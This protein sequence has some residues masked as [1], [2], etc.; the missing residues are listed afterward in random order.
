MAS[1]SFY[2]G[3][4]RQVGHQPQTSTSH[5]SYPMTITSRMPS[6]GP[7]NHVEMSGA[8]LS[9]SGMPNSAAISLPQTSTAG[10]GGLG[11]TPAPLPTATATG[12]GDFGSFTGYTTP[13]PP[14]PFAMP[15]SLP[16][17]LPPVGDGTRDSRRQNLQNGRDE[18]TR[19]EDALRG[20]LSRALSSGLSSIVGEEERRRR[21]EKERDGNARVSGPN[22]GNQSPNKRLSSGFSIGMG[23]PNMAK[24]W[25]DSIQKAFPEANREG[26]KPSNA[27]G[28]RERDEEEAGKL[29]KK[30][31]HHH[32]HSL[33]AVHHHRHHHKVDDEPA[34][35]GL[36]IPL[37]RAG[38]RSKS[39]NSM[40]MAHPHH[41]HQVTVH[42]HHPA[43]VSP[44]PP[45]QRVKTS[46]LI[47]SSKVLASLASK[48]RQYL[49]STIYQPTPTPKQ[50]L[51]VTQ[52]L[53]PRFEGRENCIFQVRIP[54]RFLSAEQRRDVHRRRCVWGT[55]V[56]TDDSD[57]LG[58]LVHLGKVPGVLP[59]GA[60][61][62][63]VAETGCRKTT[64]RGD[65]TNM[66][67]TIPSPVRK[68]GKGAHAADEGP[69]IQPGKD[70][71]VNLLILPTLQKYTGSV[72]NAL[73]SRSWNT[74]HDGMSY[75]IWD[76]E[77]VEA[78][79]AEARGG[80]SRKRR[81][82]E[83]EWVRRWGELPPSRGGGGVGKVGWNKGRWSE[84]KTGMR[85]GNVT[86]VGA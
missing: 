48:P 84:S 55:E 63:L 56:Y 69:T 4:P 59:E 62:D 72:R 10:A 79:E 64:S 73:K 28:K 20:G 9:M 30:K 16:T 46:L 47:D 42:H 14:S 15:A 5:L 74:I 40:A 18:P 45:P 81:L 35:S 13:M 38:A 44:A 53:L 75:S 43:A 50:G 1:R 34:G 76:M 39:P 17:V 11:P 77:W 61:P 29:E 41:V 26:G 33:H 52:P 2:G 82:D 57:V 51:S 19:A 66:L 12:R 7:Q 32:H 49:G 22:A 6:N 23:M 60:T 78:G 83:R 58:V 31:K 24:S 85:K 25:D 27:L 71:I 37:A 65:I 54:R 21:V 86:E 36:E 68:K 3:E 70:L 8:P 80:G 67:S